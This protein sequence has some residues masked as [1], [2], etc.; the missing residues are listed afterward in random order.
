VQKVN[1]LFQAALKELN[2]KD[3]N[4]VIAIEESLTTDH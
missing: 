1:A 3:A 4:R 2:I